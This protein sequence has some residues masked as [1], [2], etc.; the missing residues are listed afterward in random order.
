MEVSLKFYRDMLGFTVTEELPEVEGDMLDAIVGVKGGKV[1]LVHVDCGN[2]QELEL[3][4]YYAPGSSKFP[5]DFRQCDGGI[6]HVA[7]WVD[8]L[9]ELYE[10]LKAEG[11]RFNSEPFDIDDIRCV[12]MR[13]PD[14]IT[15]E[16]MQKI[17][18]E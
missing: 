7:L 9:I 18:T 2:G 4:Q 6:I 14:G 1:R 11:V 10:K 13:D 3:F 15:V 8:N 12:Y 5:Q 17:E 16:L